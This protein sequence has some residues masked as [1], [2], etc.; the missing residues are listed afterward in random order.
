MGTLFLLR[1]MSRL[2]SFCCSWVEVDV[3]YVNVRVSQKYVGK[4]TLGEFF[5]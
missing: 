4:R 2:K 5:G 3:G 1:D